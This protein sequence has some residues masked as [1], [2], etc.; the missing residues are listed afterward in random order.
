MPKGKP[1]WKCGDKNS[2]KTE[3]LLELS[4]KIIYKN[5]KCRILPGGE[6]LVERYTQCYGCIP[7]LYL[8]QN[9]A[10]LQALKCLQEK[11]EIIPLVCE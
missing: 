4:K 5:E 1:R 2:D 8:N 10:F 7:K 6:G 11:G 9:P 3:L